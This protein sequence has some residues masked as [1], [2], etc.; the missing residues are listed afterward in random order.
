MKPLF[1]TID[2]EG[3]SLWEITENPTTENVTNIP[4]FQEMCER[5]SFIPI[6]LTDYEIINDNRFVNYIKPRAHKGL[7]EVG[8]HVHPHNNP[9]FLK[10]KNETMEGELLIEYPYEIMKRKVFILKELI[11]EK[12]GQPVLSHRAGRWAFNSTYARCL[13]ELGIKYDCSVTPKLSWYSFVGAR[14]DSHGMDFT[15]FS[16]KRQ[17][18]YDDMGKCIIEYPV[19]IFDHDQYFMPNNARFKDYLKEVVHK[20]R[21]DKIWLRPTSKNLNQMKYILSKIMNDPNEKFAEFMIHSSEFKVGC[22]HLYSTE[23]QMEAFFKDIDS[24]MSF[25]K[26]IGYYGATFHTYERDFLNSRN[27]K[28]K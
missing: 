7:C 28:C 19:S 25:A 27:E 22:N 8:I 13:N 2:T 4:I 1:I 3:D 12:I 17:L 20:L 26:A 9:P 5:Y 24:M 10:L 23:R 6:W 14:H 21:N 16:R 11:E 18:F 15:Q